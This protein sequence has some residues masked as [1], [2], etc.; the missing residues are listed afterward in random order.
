MLT[1]NSP[2]LGIGELT[3]MDPNHRFT[4][5]PS[6]TRR[7]KK[8]SA[9]ERVEIDY[10]STGCFAPV[11]YQFAVARHQSGGYTLSVKTGKNHYSLAFTYDC[12]AWSRDEYIDPNLYG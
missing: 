6:I 5:D 4:T 1:A 3:G 7:L 2:S 8:M 9:G 10:L 11:N 12:I